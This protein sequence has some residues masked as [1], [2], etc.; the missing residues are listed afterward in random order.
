[1]L[2]KSKPEMTPFKKKKEKRKIEDIK[3]D[4]SELRHG[5]SESKIY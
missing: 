1:M 5:F 4:S 3:K 2:S